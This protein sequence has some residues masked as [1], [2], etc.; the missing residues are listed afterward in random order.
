MEQ[1]RQES[2][3]LRIIRK[4]KLTVMLMVVGAWKDE[5]D[6]WKMWMGFPMENKKGANTTNY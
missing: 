3:L 6:I 2:K 4:I 1:D 5:R